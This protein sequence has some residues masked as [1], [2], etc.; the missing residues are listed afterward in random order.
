MRTL[1][2]PASPHRALACLAAL[3]VLAGP[4]SALATGGVVKVSGQTAGSGYKFGRSQCADGTKLSFAWDLAAVVGVNAYPTGTSLTVWETQTSS[5]TSPAA[6]NELKY[7]VTP[8]LTGTTPSIAL[9]DFLT[10]DTCASST[11]SSATPGS[12]LLCLGYYVG[13]TNLN[14]KVI[15]FYIIEFTLT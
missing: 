3:A 14:K 11:S 10:P 15:L 5:C 1:S 12:A 8:G 7:P 6:T 4:T 13:T 9:V 2:Q